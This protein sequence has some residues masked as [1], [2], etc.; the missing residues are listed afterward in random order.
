MTKQEEIGLILYGVKIGQMS[1]DSAMKALDKLGVVIKAN[2]R[3]K[4][5]DELNF[6]AVEPL[7]EEV[8]N[9]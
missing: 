7:I 9:G 6:A 8:K 1:E 5:L 2:K 4:S 3:D